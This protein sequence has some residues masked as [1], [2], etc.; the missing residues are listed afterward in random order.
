MLKKTFDRLFNNTKNEIQN[1]YG[2]RR[3]LTDLVILGGILKRNSGNLLKNLRIKFERLPK[4]FAKFKY[5]KFVYFNGKIFMDCF[6]PAWPGVA[7]N[8]TLDGLAQH[9]LD[10]D[11]NWEDFTVALIISI[12]KKCVYRCEH[13]YAIQTLG[14]EDVLDYE[15]LLNIS[16]GFQKLGIGVIAWEGGEPLLRFDELLNLIKQTVPNSEAWIATTAYGLTNDQARLLKEAGLAAAIISLDHYN[17]AKHNEFRKNKKAYDMVIKGVRIFRENGIL[18][19]ICVCATRE[20]L[21]EGDGLWKYL[22][23]AKKIGVAYVQILDATPS[24]NYIDK[25]VLLTNKQLNS[26]K[27]FHIEVNTDSRYRDYPGISARA[28]LESDDYYG[29]SAGNALVYLDSS[30]NLQACDLLQISFGNVLEEG[31]ENVYKRMKSYFPRF[32]GGRCPAQTLHKY[33]SNVYEKQ[34][35]LP[36]Q[37][38][39]CEE[40][41]EKIVKRGLPRSLQFKHL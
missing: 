18:P 19:N 2:F 39:N 7:F 35:S 25:D 22:E 36:L 6:A 33:I 13:C 15:Q 8:R 9:F 20:L 5:N 31:V 30:G 4:V 16:K 14:S 28:L 32:K 23:L 11:F 1:I 41:L 24:G 37:Y 3:A 10:K 21:E 17:R 38:E 26:I 29:C 40:V 12:T 27:K 34:Q